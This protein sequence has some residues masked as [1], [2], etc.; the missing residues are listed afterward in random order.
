MAPLLHSPLRPPKKRKIAKSI[1]LLITSTELGQSLA[2]FG[3]AVK[4]IGAFD[5]DSLGRAFS[6]VGA[7]SEALSVKLLAEVVLFDD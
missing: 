6:G 5:E 1:V 2:E 7:E 4:L 3:K